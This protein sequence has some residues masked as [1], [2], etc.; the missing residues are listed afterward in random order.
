MPVI[1]ARD[2]VRE[3]LHV[4]VPLQNAWRWRSRWKHVTRA[5]K[6]FMDS[7]AVI[8]LVEA[9]FNRREHVFADSGLDGT[10]ATCSLNGGE[11]RHRYIPLRSKS[12]IWLKENLINLGVQSLPW[13]WEQVAWNDSDIL[14]VRPNWVG[15]AIHKLQHY[16]FLQMFSHAQDADPQY[17]LLP[18]T[19]Y[20]DSDSHTSYG[21][22]FVHA[23]REALN[24]GKAFIPPGAERHRRRRPQAYPY[25][26]RPW[27]GL[28][29]ACTREAWDEVGG[30]LDICI[31]GGGDWT[32]AH[33]LIGKRRYGI[34]AGVHPHY[35][36]IVNAWADLCDRHIRRNIGYMDGTVI[37]NWHGRKN[38]RGY[39][40]R[41]QTLADAHFDPTRHLKR[42][43]QGMWQLHDDGSEDYIT[44][45]DT[46][47]HSSMHRNED[48]T[49]VGDPFP[50]QGGQG[51]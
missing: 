36:A 12:E 22:G 29:W 48:V 30:L 26:G 14:F 34:H 50:T 32:M 39:G 38:E 33:C 17:R 9:A 3:P 25:A 28:A 31:W 19:F 46:I 4:V 37:H 47:R 2:V 44:L 10:L 35:L 8:T 45:R 15:E 16:K 7:G 1:I 24:L 40:L 43:Y 27:P 51:H 41:H 18:P 21:D 6:H 5:I 23:W 42:D 49:E 13:K 20:K 11:F